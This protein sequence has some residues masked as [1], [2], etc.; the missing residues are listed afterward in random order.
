MWTTEH[1]VETAA[2]PETI[3]QLWADVPRWPE[4][5]ADI[6][7]V[8]L[9]GPFAAGSTIRMASL[10]DEVV[11]LRIAEATERSSFVDVADFGELV[12]RTIHRLDAVAGGTRVTYRM[13]ID[14]PGA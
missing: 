3:W 2:A 11:E 12:V 7:R 8:E 1:A 13:E 5:N 9:D 4:W 14:G 10:E 6:A